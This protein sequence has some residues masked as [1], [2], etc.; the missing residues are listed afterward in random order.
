MLKHRSRKDGLPAPIQGK[1]EDVETPKGGGMSH[2][3]LPTTN[4]AL[5]KASDEEEEEEGGKESKNDVKIAF[6]WQDNKL[7][8]ISGF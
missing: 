2:F 5:E 4:A 1:G 6:V 3:Q 7:K 8:H